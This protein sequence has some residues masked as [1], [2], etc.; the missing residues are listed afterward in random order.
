MA[1]LSCQTYTPVMTGLPITLY[2]PQWGCTSDLNLEFVD[3]VPPTA[4]TPAAMAAFIAGFSASFTL[5]NVSLATS[6]STTAATFTALFAPLSAIGINYACY[7]FHTFNNR[8]LAQTCPCVTLSAA[9][10][11]NCSAYVNYPVSVMLNSPL[12]AP[13]VLSDPSLTSLFAFSCSDCQ[14]AATQFAC[15]AAFPQC[16]PAPLPGF[17]P[18]SQSVCQNSLTT[19]RAIQ[20]TD[21]EITALFALV[22]QLPSLGSA[23]TAPNVSTILNACVNFPPVGGFTPVNYTALPQCPCV[24]LSASTSKCA[25][26]VGHDVGT[27]LANLDIVTRATLEGTVLGFDAGFDYTGCLNCKN[28]VDYTLCNAIY[29][30]CTTTQLAVRACLSNCTTNVAF[31]TDTNTAAICSTLSG[32]FSTNVATCNPVEYE[33]LHCT[34]SSTNPKSSAHSTPKSSTHS[35]SS[36]LMPSFFVFIL[37]ALFAKILF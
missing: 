11:G 33:D 18:V 4:N 36:S 29:P 17:I 37:V 32:A 22:S 14:T 9:T 7:D 34:T 13:A 5:N 16:L 10:L 26:F 12:I 28:A 24:P 20:Y 23:F 30:I 19:C 6:F 25:S 31:C 27:F 1:Y 21:P 2:V 15:L 3:C 35:G 8:T